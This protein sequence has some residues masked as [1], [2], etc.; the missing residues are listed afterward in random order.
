MDRRQA[1]SRQAILSAFR[2]LLSKKRFEQISVREILTAADVCRSTFYAHFET[3]DSLLDA[4]CGEIFDH[5]FSGEACDYPQPSVGFEAMLSHILYHLKHERQDVTGLLSSE[6]GT[7]FAARLTMQF[8]RLV[9]PYCT[10][11]P[12]DVSESFGLDFLSSACTETVRWWAK[13][14]MN[15]EPELL[16]HWVAALLRL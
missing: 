16:A 9:L 6:S 3:K 8:R 12:E 2:D 4:L 11:L 7:L 5:I 1:R 14:G 10:H 15:T 13:E